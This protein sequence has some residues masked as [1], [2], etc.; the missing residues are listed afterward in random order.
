MAP[1][2]LPIL[3]FSWLLKGCKG[4]EI[5]RLENSDANQLRKP[6]KR[7][8]ENGSTITVIAVVSGSASLLLLLYY[9]PA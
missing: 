9:S 4:D 6:P 7:E 1:F 8:V 3:G 2:R 5:H